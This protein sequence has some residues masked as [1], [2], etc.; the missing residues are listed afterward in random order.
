MT[1]LAIVYVKSKRVGGF[2]IVLSAEELLA[3]K[4]GAWD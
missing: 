1:C 2:M 4:E 3:M